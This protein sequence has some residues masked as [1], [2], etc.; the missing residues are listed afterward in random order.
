MAQLAA[1]LRRVGAW[2]AAEARADWGSVGP[3]A[4]VVGTVGTPGEVARARLRARTLAATGSG[5]VADAVV[6]A[7]AGLTRSA[8]IAVADPTTLAAD[9]R[10]VNGTTC[11]SAVLTMLAALGDPSL[12]TWL[13]TG[14]LATDPDD[15]RPPELA[16]ANLGALAVL[17]DAPV[18]RRFAAVQRVYQRRTTSHALLGL[19]WPSA[20]GTPPWGAAR[21]ARFPGVVFGH[22][23]L[24]DADRAALAAVLDGVGRA[25][26]A[27]VPVPL[28]SGGDTARGWGTAVPRHVVLAVSRAGDGLRIFEPGRGRMV[29]ATR[30]ALLAGQGPQPAL[31]G[32]PHLV[33]VLPPRSVAPDAEAGHDGRVPS[34]PSERW[35]DE[36]DPR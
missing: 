27:G 32:W 21:A 14:R 23:P 16:G 30:A 3:A 12:A 19:P 29:T 36:Y 2:R 4:V 25:V 18:S 34:D 10:Q 35:R 5:D 33:W 24:D 31:G 22:H 9:A 13:A 15:Q 8:R 7:W 26:D 17:A 11:G 6:R 28:Y 1:V 20:L